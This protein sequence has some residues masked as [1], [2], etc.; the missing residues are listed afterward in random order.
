MLFAYQ[1]GTELFSAIFEHYFHDV[2][3]PILFQ[4]LVTVFASSAALTKLAGAYIL[5]LAVLWIIYVF[6]KNR[7]FQIAVFKRCQWQIVRR[8]IVF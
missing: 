3:Q 4:L 2:L 1:Q 5:A 8:N 6:Y 7:K